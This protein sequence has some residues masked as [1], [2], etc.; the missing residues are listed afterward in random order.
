MPTSVVAAIAADAIATAVADAVIFD[1]VAATTLDWVAT[2]AVIQAGTSFVAGSMIRS[3]LSGGAEDAPT[4]SPSFT[5][6]AE[7]RTHVIRS[8]VANRQIIY[9]RAMV[10]GPIV[11]AASANNNNNLHLVIVL[12]GHE[13]DAIEEIWFG[14]ELVGPRDINGHVTSG[15]FYNHTQIIEHLGAS[16]QAADANLVALDA[17]WTS[18]HQL[19]GCAYLHVHINYDRDV[20]PRGIPNIKALVRGKKLYDPRDA[21]TAW[22]QNLALAVRD[23]LAG[24]YGL[25]ST[26]AEIDDTAIIAA[27][28]ICDESVALAAGGTEARYTVNGVLDTGNTPRANMEALLSGC[29]GAVTWPAGRWTLHVG[30]YESPVLS[31]DED[32]LAGP[33]QVRARVPRQDL[34]N[35][36]KGTYIDP[37]QGYQPVDFPA[38]TNSTYATQD[39]AQIFRDVALPVT[40]SSATAQ[41]LCKMMVEKS[42]QGITVQAPFKLTAFKAATWDNVT[43]SI[44]TLGWS[45]KVFKVTSW[46]F[47]ESGS[48]GLT[49]QEEA[50]A[51][52]TWSAEET[53][54]DPAPD[55]N[56]PAWDSVV[57]PESLT[58]SSG[59]TELLLQNDGTIESRIKAVWPA[60][61]NAFVVGVELQ[62]KP[63]SSSEWIAGPVPS[64][65]AS[66]AY[67]GGV[68]DAIAYDVRVRFISALGVRSAWTQAAAHTVIGK[69]AL[70]PSVDSFSV[71]EQP[72]GARQFFW[73]MHDAPLDLMSWIVR[74]SPGSTRRDWSQMAALFS[75][76]RDSRSSSELDPIGDGVY[77]FAIKAVDTTGNES[78][79]PLYTDAVFDAASLG[80]LAA[81][82]FSHQVGWP[83]T[84]SG[85]Y[86]D[87]GALFNMGA[88]TWNDLAAV[89]WTSAAYPWRNTSGT[90]IYTTAVLDA[91]AVASHAYR[92]ASVVAGTASVEIRL[93]N[94][95][96]TW[97][98]WAAVSSSPATARYFQFRFTTTSTEDAV[99]Y[100]A[101]ALVY[102]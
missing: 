36:V 74:Y 9:G 46:Q 101:Q 51:C 49:L 56:L 12:A 70:P 61:S 94:D 58:L 99:M 66:V 59:T 96:I 63:S 78:A 83:G 23:Y 16:D 27:A 93:S 54:A 17:G 1:I 77:V 79:L 4:A 90:I 92:V 14:D 38:I 41:R 35:A 98:S 50:A 8:A 39:G 100:R 21:S 45:S 5:A 22:S 24:S 33:V 15:K 86:I 72:G 60:S 64:A 91:G 37:L 102:A 84:L 55:T 89:D 13:C 44:G 62:Y 6:Q 80:T 25:A 71:I 95:N 53:I 68:A 42:R 32:D 73:S 3:A 67:I 34:Y 57:A 40:T 47:N 2:Y 87:G 69:T 31:L 26:S 75:S 88:L 43:L 81:Y 19:R 7:N 29:C 85:A 76:G 28:N 48:V 30:A 18:A 52:Y 11:F 82:E 97:S 20:F 65:D 10:S